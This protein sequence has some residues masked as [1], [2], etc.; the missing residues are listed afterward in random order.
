[1]WKTIKGRRVFIPEDQSEEMMAKQMNIHQLQHP[2]GSKKINWK[3]RRK[4]R[5]K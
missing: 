1:M 5:K 4:S 3:K 2:K